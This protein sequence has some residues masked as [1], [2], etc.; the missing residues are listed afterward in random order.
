MTQ[1]Y[2][3]QQTII[4]WRIPLINGKLGDP[5]IIKKFTTNYGE[6]KIGYTKKTPPKTKEI[7]EITQQYL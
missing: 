4:Q 7:T 6:K 3:Y 1:Q 2:I 5:E